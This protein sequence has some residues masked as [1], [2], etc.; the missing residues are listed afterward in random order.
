M[1]FFTKLGSA[2]NSLF[3]KQVMPDVQSI[4]KKG[5][6]GR[7]FSKMAGQAA[8]LAGV[9]GRELRRGARNQS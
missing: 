3:K 7:K 1:S 4:F 2:G 9:A 8:D 5:G 6:V